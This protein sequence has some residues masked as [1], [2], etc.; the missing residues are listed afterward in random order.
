[1]RHRKNALLKTAIAAGVFALPIGTRA[2]VGGPY[3]LSWNTLDG[4]GA[5]FSTGGAYRLGG[6]AGQPD[7][8]R[9]A[10]GV[11]VLDGGFFHRG[12]AATSVGEPPVLPGDPPAPDSPA[13]PLAF[14]LY[15]GA[16]NPFAQKTTLAFDL[17]QP[18]G[19]RARIYSTSGELVRTLLDE[20]HPAGR[21]AVAWDGSDAAG[22]D[23][24]HGV[25]VLQLKAGA[26][27]GTQKLI[28]TR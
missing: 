28:L 9:H 23:V 5:T 15:P 26:F 7:A 21:H 20:A 12:I 3:N 10:G 19:V 16:P 14:R 11:Y 22:R 1:M 13:I 4:G 8:G 6:A 17:P 27:S 24:A 25:Y 2:Q 18:A